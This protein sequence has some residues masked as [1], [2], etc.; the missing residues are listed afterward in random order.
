MIETEA[1][2]TYTYIKAVE[3]IKYIHPSAE[4]ISTP[5]KRYAYL[6]ESLKIL[7][8]KTFVGKNT[9]LKKAVVGH[10]VMHAVRPRTVIASLQICLGA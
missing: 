10:A 5:E 9:Q 1:N 7:L 6:P 8:M 4:D 2:L 3:T